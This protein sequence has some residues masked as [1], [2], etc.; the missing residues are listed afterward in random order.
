[1]KNSWVCGVLLCVWLI[2]QGSTC[3]TL[4]GKPQPYSGTV[5]SL[6][7]Y[8]E[9]RDH[10]HRFISCD[11]SFCTL[12]VTVELWFH[13]PT[14]KLQRIKAQCSYLLGGAKMYQQRF[15]TL[16]LPGKKSVQFL[17]DYFV[18]IERSRTDVTVDCTADFTE[19]TAASSTKFSAPAPSSL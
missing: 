1:M 6:E 15:K 2:V 18:Q 9:L 7:P 11:R 3:N 16:K 17:T 4:V 10:G 5:G 19:M 12:D 8:L 14:S 13:N